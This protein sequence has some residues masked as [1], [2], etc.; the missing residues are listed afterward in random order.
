MIFAAE[1]LIV[2]HFGRM[3]AVSLLTPLAKISK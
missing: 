1:A 3:S 2:Y